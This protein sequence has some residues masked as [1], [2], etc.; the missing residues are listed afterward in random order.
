MKTRKI[1]FCLMAVTALAKPTLGGGLQGGKPACGVL[2]IIPSHYALGIPVP[3]GGKKIKADEAKRA[4][5]QLSLQ[6]HPDKQGDAE[7]KDLCS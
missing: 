3:W 2:D 5:R 7:K 6:Y 1:L 4:F